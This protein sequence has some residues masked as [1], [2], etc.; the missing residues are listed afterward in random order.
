MAYTCENERTDQKN[1][2]LPVWLIP[3]S[4][5]AGSGA[6]AEWLE[7]LASHQAA[8]NPRM[9]LQRSVQ[10]MLELQQSSKVSRKPIRWAVH[11]KTPEG[12]KNG[13]AAGGENKQEM[14]KLQTTGKKTSGNREEQFKKQT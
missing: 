9:V 4:L 2:F 10:L 3:A 11:G 7:H 14:L 12:C 13:K 1:S 8:R 5:G 6:G